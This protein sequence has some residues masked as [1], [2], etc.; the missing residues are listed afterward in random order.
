M[1]LQVYATVVSSLAAVTALI[2]MIPLVV[3]IPFLFAWDFI[4]FALW[5]A[6]FGIFGSMFIKEH[7]EGNG[8]ITRM[9]NAVVCISPFDVSHI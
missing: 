4:L 5:I 3:R 7:A 8:G 6:L 1:L 2:Y 9:K